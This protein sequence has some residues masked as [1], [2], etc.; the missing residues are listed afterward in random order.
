MVGSLVSLALVSLMLPGGYNI[1]LEVSNSTFMKLALYDDTAEAWNQRTVDAFNANR[2][3]TVERGTC[4][5]T[6]ADNPAESYGGRIGGTGNLRLDGVNV[7]SEI[8]TDGCGVIYAAEPTYY[9]GSRNRTWVE[10]GVL[11]LYVGQGC[12]S[13]EVNGTWD[14]L[15]MGV[16]G[17]GRHKEYLLPVVE[18]TVVLADGGV[19]YNET[20]V[21]GSGGFPESVDTVKVIQVNCS[22]NGSDTIIRLEHTCRGYVLL[23]SAYLVMGWVKRCDRERYMKNCLEGC[24][25]ANAAG[26]KSTGGGGGTGG[27]CDGGCCRS[28]CTN[29][30]NHKCREDESENAVCPDVPSGQY[31]SPYDGSSEYFIGKPGDSHPDPCYCHHLLDASNICMNNRV[32][33]AASQ[34]YEC[35]DVREYT[36]EIKPRLTCNGSYFKS[37]DFGQGYLSLEVEPDVA[38]AFIVG[39]IPYRFQTFAPR[40]ILYGTVEAVKYYSLAD[41]DYRINESHEDSG[42]FDF[43]YYETVENKY[44]PRV[45]EGIVLDEVSGGNGSYR[46]GFAVSDAGR[47]GNL[48]L[49]VLTVGDRIGGGRECD[50]GNP[51]PEGIFCMDGRCLNLGEVENQTVRFSECLTEAKQV[52]ITLSVPDIVGERSSATAL[53]TLSAGG[54]LPGRTVSFG[55]W[56]WR[57]NATTDGGG[58]ASFTFT[59]GVGASLCTASYGG[60]YQYS[61]ATAEKWVHTAARGPDFRIW[62]MFIAL[63]LVIAIIFTAASGGRTIYDVYET[64]R[65]FMR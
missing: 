9:E 47:I 38:T 7:S 23:D 64:L 14:N 63:L 12:T 50:F 36:I 2:T 21:H 49:T 52:N 16:P 37:G 41:G 17:T 32:S 56:G 11:S 34:G 24:S 13:R 18:E 4:S 28:V 10:E 1:N 22:V 60:D 40:H 51:C 39:D 29:Q 27:S 20:V 58:R 55:C 62:L 31:G 43:A 30:A 57:Q 61:P 42:Y 45:G 6:T 53:V 3:Y 25:A 54:P 33:L 59:S 48:T 19:C 8:F 44:P 26:S 35:T 5:N 46:T 65:G 15:E